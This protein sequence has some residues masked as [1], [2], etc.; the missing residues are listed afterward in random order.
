MTNH[1]IIVGDGDF[2]PKEI[3]AEVVK[4]KIIVALD[5][6]ADRLAHLGLMPQIILGDFDGDSAEHAAFWGIRRSGSQLEDDDEAAYPGTH[7]VSIVPR[8]NQNLTDLA[9]AII[10]CDEL[11]AAS[12]TLICATGGR[13]DHHEAA[14]R[15]LRAAYKKERMIM[16]HT[17]Q[18]SIRFAK[19]ESLVIE[20]E[21]GDKCAL[22]AF[23][24]AEFS[25]EGLVY[26]GRHYPLNFA[27]SE[28]VGNVLKVARAKVEI[29]GEA[30]VML[31]PQL[32]SQ[33]AFMRKSRRERARVLLGEMV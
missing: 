21:I 9:K 27:F 7:G 15:C 20:G 2:L 17:E 32:A 28:S 8:K 26:E 13:L 12:I 4:D 29:H 10:Y 23:P 18:Q 25:S 11:G 22:F 6:A 3:I 5:A 1:Y 30:L 16:L 33:R 14:M 24:Q 31:P 19:N